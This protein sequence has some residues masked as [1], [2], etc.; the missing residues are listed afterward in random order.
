[1]FYFDIAF[2]LTKKNDI[3]DMQKNIGA[4]ETALN[5]IIISCPV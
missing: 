2:C 3:Q 1:M 5:Y 4:I